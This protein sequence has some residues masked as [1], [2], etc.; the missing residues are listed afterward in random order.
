MKLHENNTARE[1]ALISFSG[2][3]N[4]HYSKWCSPE[5]GHKNK[6]IPRHVVKSRRIG[7]GPDAAKDWRLKEKGVAEDE[8]VR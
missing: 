1:V 3:K 8:M 2:S 4:S 6:G 5:I 7:K